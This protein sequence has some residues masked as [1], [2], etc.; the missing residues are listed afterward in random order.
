QV[1]AANPELSLSPTLPLQ[2]QMSDHLLL[3]F[4]RHPFKERK[5]IVVMLWRRVGE[6]FNPERSFAFFASPG[7]VLLPTGSD[8]LWLLSEDIAEIK[9]LFQSAKLGDRWK[10]KASAMSLTR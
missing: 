8:P 5:V 4:E 3:E 9:F 10:I 2:G 7:K 6:D 1:K